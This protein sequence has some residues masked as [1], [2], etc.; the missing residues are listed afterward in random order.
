MPDM[1]KIKNVVRASPFNRVLSVTFW[2]TVRKDFGFSV[3][4]GAARVLRLHFGD[5]IAFDI[6]DTSGKRLYRGIARLKSETEIYGTDFKTCLT[7]GDRMFV[8]ASHPTS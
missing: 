6:W 8:T 2:T 5:E 1:P 4:Q 7:R 3:P